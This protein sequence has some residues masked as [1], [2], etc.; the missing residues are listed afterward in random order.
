MRHCQTYFVYDWHPEIDDLKKKAIL[1]EVIAKNFP[2]PIKDI[3]LQ[4]QRA[5][6]KKNPKVLRKP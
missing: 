1:E 5:E 2:K 4:I 3:N 6:Q